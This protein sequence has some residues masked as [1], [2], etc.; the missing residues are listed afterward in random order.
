MPKIDKD[1]LL[2]ATEF[3]FWVS[4]YNAAG[5]N[6][7]CRPP[8][9]AIEQV[10]RCAFVVCSSLPRSMESAK[11]L[12]IESIDVCE[13]MFRE[14]DMPHA[15]RSFP[16]LS[17]AMWTVLFRLIWAVGYSANTESF[18]E[19]RER[20]RSCAQRLA[21]LASV[22]GTVLL[23]GHGLLNWF[24]AWHLKKMGWSGP[25]KSPRNYWDFAMYR[26]SSRRKNSHE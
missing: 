18:K 25:Q 1:R 10:S 21:E 2:N 26:T 4:E 17:P 20:A 23:V 19:A 3:G 16:R 11:A 8:Q 9:H 22:H 24:I 13:A 6:V 5:I 14:M 7:G 15:N 12:G